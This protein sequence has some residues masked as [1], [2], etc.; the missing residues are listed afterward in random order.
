MKILKSPIS[1]HYELTENCNHRC[2]HCYN[3]FAHISEEVPKLTRDRIIEELVQNEVFHVILTGGEPLFYQDMAVDAVKRLN[4]NG[5]VVSLNSNL[6]LM[7]RNTAVSLKKA[8]LKSALTSITHYDPNIHDKITKIDGS[9]ERCI[10]G[11]NY[12]VNQEIPVSVNMVV[13]KDRVDDVYKTGEMLVDL[14]ITGFSA[15]RMAPNRDNLKEILDAQE[16]KHMLDQLLL[17]KEKYGINVS[18]L[19]N[20]PRCFSSDKKYGIF[21][22][23]SCNGGRTSA[24][25]TQI[26]GLKSCHHLDEVVGNIIEEGLSTVWEKAP[27]LKDERLPKGCL[28]C[29]VNENCAGG[30]RQTA[31]VVRNKKT[32]L[33]PIARGKEQII[34][35]DPPE[36]PNKDS[37]LRFMKDTLY[38]KEKNGGVLFRNPR[39]YAILNESQY[40]LALK[41]SNNSFSINELKDLFGNELSSFME[42]LYQKGLIGEAKWKN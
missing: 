28:A 37:T 29:D 16:V 26:G 10:S 30:C 20:L 8:G 4:K 42:R 31:E 39:N 15:T 12:L 5:A 7:D 36:L 17:L 25:I 14:G 13:T 27:V 21:M 1:V 22:N 35:L 6:T 33:D 9:L 11:I 40:Q 18:S 19:N 32:G 2:E 34:T 3:P 24:T 41:L 23:R 38:R